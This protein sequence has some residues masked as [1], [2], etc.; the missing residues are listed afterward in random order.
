M[1]ID[2]RIEDIE[3]AIKLYT[4]WIN[5]PESDYFQDR[6]LMNFI[7]RHTKELDLLI[8][9]RDNRRCLRLINELEA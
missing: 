5:D 2:K 9:K 7:L 6:L 3:A 1:N 8:E 4:G